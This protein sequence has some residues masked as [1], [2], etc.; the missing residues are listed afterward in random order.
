MNRRAAAERGV[1]LARISVHPDAAALA[2]LVDLADRGLLIPAVHAT[3]EL[4]KAGDAHE[5]LNADVHGK[6][7]LVP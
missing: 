2:S 6:L 7:V 1:R 3:F 4:E 5:A